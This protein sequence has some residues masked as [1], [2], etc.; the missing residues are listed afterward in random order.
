MRKNSYRLL[1][2]ACLKCGIAKWNI[3]KIWINQT[4]AEDWL[5]TM[6]SRI[7]SRIAHCFV[8]ILGSALSFYYVNYG[9][10]I[11][12][13]KVIFEISFLLKHHSL[14]FNYWDYLTN[15]WRNNWQS[16]IDKVERLGLWV[17]IKN[18]L[19]PPPILE[20]AST[21]ARLKAKFNL[22][23]YVWVWNVLV[24]SKAIQ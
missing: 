13:S 5:G 23:R 8:Y 3:A 15:F 24:S 16:L 11:I 12:P 1:I 18:V 4:G 20:Q 2:Q 10:S 6:G 19:L 14:C 17:D 7:L 21:K 22:S 9:S